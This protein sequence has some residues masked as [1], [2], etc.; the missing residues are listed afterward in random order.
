M[1]RTFLA[2]TAASLIALFF[3][4]TALSHGTA[5][6]LKGTVGPGFTIKLTN[7][8]KSFKSLPAGTYAITVSD[9]SSIHNFVLV[10][11]G[12]SAKTLTAVGFTG[13]KTVTVKLT[14][15]SWTFYCAP[16]ASFMFGKFAV[17]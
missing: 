2:A 16:H 10:R 3:T 4:A 13:T 11:T 1:Y 8:G 12:G 5:A 14:K 9:R 17:K 7:A 15:G 6:T